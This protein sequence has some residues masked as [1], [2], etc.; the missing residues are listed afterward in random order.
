MLFEYSIF[1]IKQSLAAAVNRVLG[2]ELVGADDFIFP[3]DSKMG[4]LC[5]PC[6]SLAQKMKVAPAVVAQ[7]IL[8]KLS[9]ADLSKDQKVWRGIQVAGPYLNFK[10]SSK[11]ATQIITQVEEMAGDYGKSSS[12]KYQSPRR[13]MIEYSN[14]NTHKEYHIG[15][16]RNITYG[17]AVGKILSA[18]G[19]EVLP[20]S[21]I[22]DFGI[23][24]AKTLWC[25]ASQYEKGVENEQ[26]NKG[27]F[28]GKVYARASQELEK[29]K[30][31]KQMVEFI[32]KKIESRQGEE[33]EL[34]QKTHQW[35]IDQFAAIY[36]ELGIN[37]SKIFYENEYIDEGKQTVA[38]LLEQGFLEKS[39]GAVIK[40]LSEYGLGAFLLLRSDGTALYPV[41][42]IPLARAK[43]EYN[44]QKSIYVVDTRQSLY[45]K[46]LFK[47]LDLLGVDY[48][49]VHL[50]YEAVKLP[51]GAMSSRTGNVITYRELRD[52]LTDRAIEEIKA[53]HSDWSEEKIKQTAHILTI[54]AMKFE[55]LKV[56]SDQ[57]ITFDIE[58]ALSFDGFTAGY[59]QYACARIQSILNKAEVA[60]HQIARIVDNEI[61]GEREIILAT[62]LAK[63]PQIVKLAGD[64]YNPSEIAKYLFSLAQSFSDYYHSVPVLQEENNDLL[65]ARLSV[66]RSV[67]QVFQNGLGLLGVEI[68]GEM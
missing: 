37:F 67:K 5:L 39:E 40:D 20:V 28:L 16:L 26:E 58:K 46:Q 50:G 13:V 42:D 10:L 32:M 25:L 41:A 8:E 38:Q 6:F 3:P 17:D 65:L 64:K 56:G 7:N 14:A 35:S 19:F 43:A 24:V 45:F 9:A 21:Y 59:I 22:N 4:D 1:Q 54:G 12:S 55:M 47:A 60:G 11:I 29:E 48:E 66:L 51:D 57:V 27:E 2:A 31:G 33:Y 61:L 52:K 53:R 44:I 36:E 15:H 49:K 63:Y 34:W 23:H 68:L 18:N 30:T 62:E